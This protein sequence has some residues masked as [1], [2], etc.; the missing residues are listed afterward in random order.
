MCK[1]GLIKDVCIT[2]RASD[3]SWQPILS[4]GHSSRVQLV[5]VSMA[6]PSSQTLL[7]QTSEEK[8]III[9]LLPPTYFLQISG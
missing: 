4:L 6:V 5:H 2:T 7:G 8:H 9:L 1:H 3:L